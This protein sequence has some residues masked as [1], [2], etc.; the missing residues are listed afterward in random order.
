MAMKSLKQRVMICGIELIEWSINSPCAMYLICFMVGTYGRISNSIYRII[1]A[2]I[3]RIRSEP[4]FSNVNTSGV[5]KDKNIISRTWPNILENM[6][7]AFICDGNRRYMNKL[8]LR[9]NFMRKEGLKKIYEFIE[10]GYHNRL[11]EVSFFCFA[12]RNFKRPR[13]EV[14]GLMAIIKNKDHKAESSKLKPKFRVYGRLELLEEEVRN[15]LC[16]LEEETKENLDIVVNIFFAYSA[17]DEISSG[18]LFNSHVDLV[19][20]TGGV[21]RLSDFMLRQVASGTAVFFSEA[22]WPEFTVVHLYLILLKHHL[23]N[24]YL[25]SYFC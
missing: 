11:K 15:E 16:R 6:S 19:I 10:F 20:R 13:N 23:E 22:L 24:K 2:V 7:V 5:C 9:D 1:G 8:G 18:I 21:R 25:L 14:D 17:E 12:L 4:Y 3:C